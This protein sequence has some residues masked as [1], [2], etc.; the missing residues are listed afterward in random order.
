VLCFA[1]ERLKVCFASER[2]AICTFRG[3]FQG[4]FARLAFVFLFGG[5]YSGDGF[6]ALNSVK[7][8]FEKK[9]KK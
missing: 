8:A 1:S 2:L 9:P 4:Y 7:K 3:S 5:I 6:N